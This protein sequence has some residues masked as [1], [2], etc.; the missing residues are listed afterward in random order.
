MIDLPDENFRVLIGI[1]ALDIYEELYWD[2]ADGIDKEPQSLHFFSSRSSEHFVIYQDCQTWMPN[3]TK[4]PFEMKNLG[5]LGRNILAPIQMGEACRTN[6]NANS[7]ISYVRLQKVKDE[8][9]YFLTL[10][11]SNGNSLCFGFGDDIMWYESAESENR[12]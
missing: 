7:K 6:K 4:K 3:I 11:F 1:S 12:L 5:T 2:E 10:F 9:T 8:G